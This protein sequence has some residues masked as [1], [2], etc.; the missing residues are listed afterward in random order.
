MCRQEFQEI[1]SIGQGNFSKVFRVK[2]KFDGMEYALK[3]S[4]RAVAS[5][6]EAKRWQQVSTA[7]SHMASLCKL[8]GDSHSAAAPR[9]AHRP[10]TLLARGPRQK[11]SSVV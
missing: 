1:A 6:L 10:P 2:S 9:H 3:R 11:W 8:R 4:F 7:G 5:E